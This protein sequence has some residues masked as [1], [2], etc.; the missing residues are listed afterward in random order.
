MDRGLS[1]GTTQSGA[2]LRERA[3]TSQADLNVI[4]ENP[5]VTDASNGKDK[6]GKTF[7]RT[8]DGTGVYSSLPRLQL[9]SAASILPIVSLYVNL[10]CL[11]L[12][13]ASDA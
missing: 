12:H 8:P 11:S 10:S 9:G 1:T 4:T 3:V 2:G 5:T 7:G 13:G 6:A